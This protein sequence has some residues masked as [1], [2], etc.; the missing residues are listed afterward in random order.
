MQAS[1]GETKIDGIPSS[2]LQLV[3]TYDKVRT[4]TYPSKSQ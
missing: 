4:D 2:L 3:E 1:P